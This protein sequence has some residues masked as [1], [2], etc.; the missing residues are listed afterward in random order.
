VQTDLLDLAILWTGLRVRLAAGHQAG[1]ARRE[2]LKVLA[3]A[4]AT[5]GPSC[6]LDHEQRYADAL[7]DLRRALEHGA[8]PAV[9]S[10]DRALIH[11]ARGDRAAARASL[12][13]VLR[14]DP[15]HP[16]ARDLRDQLQRQHSL[17][18]RGH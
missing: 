2:A 7:A 14:H 17:P 9:V 11:L 18:R 6:V 15:R 5:F 10:Y 4:E 3:E 1:A 12:D 16:G 8:D 13:D